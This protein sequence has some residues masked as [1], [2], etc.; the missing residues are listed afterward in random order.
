M[1]VSYYKRIVACICF[2]LFPLLSAGLSAL[3]FP[4]MQLWDEGNP[5]YNWKAM[6]L[7]AVLTT[8]SWAQLDLNTVI[9]IR[10]FAESSIRPVHSQMPSQQHNEYLIQTLV[11]NAP[12]S[13]VH[14]NIVA[15]GHF[16][17]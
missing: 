7:P 8:I 16:K 12:A 9:H 5:T 15:Q 13:Y 4:N 10:G 3:S 14:S 2:L 17:F 1:D 11:S 6:P